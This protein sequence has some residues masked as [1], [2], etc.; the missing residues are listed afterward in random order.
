MQFINNIAVCNGKCYE[1][2]S[3][4]VCSTKNEPLSENNSI[5]LQW[6]KDKVWDPSVPVAMQ[7]SILDVLDFWEEECNKDKRI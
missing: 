2:K 3:L 1:C 6:L 5:P 4:K 7:E